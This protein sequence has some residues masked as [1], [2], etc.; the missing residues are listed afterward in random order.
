V[1]QEHYA[2][3]ASIRD[4]VAENPTVAPHVAAFATAG[5]EIALNKAYERAADMEVALVCALSKRRK[6]MDGLLLTK[7]KKWEGRTSINWETEIK[8]LSSKN[9]DQA[10]GGQK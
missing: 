6:D 3:L 1:N 10:R 4:Y 8:Q 2:F 9:S 7:L 5:I